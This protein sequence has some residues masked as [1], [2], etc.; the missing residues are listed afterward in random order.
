MPLGVAYRDWLLSLTRMEADTGCPRLFGLKSQIAMYFA[1][2]ARDMPTEQRFNLM[3]AGVKI[4][5]QQNYGY[6][7]VPLT[8]QER[9][10]WAVFDYPLLG[11]FR[12]ASKPAAE[13]TWATSGRRQV[14][15]ADKAAAV[16][17]WEQLE[18]GGA[19]KVDKT[20]LKTTIK[21]SMRP[22]FGVPQMVG[23]TWQYK[24]FVPGLMITTNLDFGG[25]RPSQLRYDQ[26]VSIMS[27]TGALQLLDHGGV[28]ALLGWPQTE[29]SYLTDA[30]APAAA[31][32]LARLCT[33]FVEAVPTM[34]E[35]SGLASKS[36]RR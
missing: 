27:E 12:T 28:S 22:T 26:C 4:L 2:I 10:A 7:A 34:F 8:D 36:A 20:L 15:D 9:A 1:D 21:G 18:F 30:D 32:L 3:S 5:C 24:T 25:R 6:P 35:R 33:E 23:P 14:V 31:A 17:R 11:R 19:F 29:W 16:L 13:I